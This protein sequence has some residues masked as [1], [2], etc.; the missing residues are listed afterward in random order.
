MALLCD[1]CVRPDLN[2]LLVRQ[3]RS[4]AAS[5]QRVAY[6][7]CH[8]L[9]HQWFVLLAVCFIACL[10]CTGLCCVQVRKLGDDAYVS[11]AVVTLNVVALRLSQHDLIFCCSTA[12]VSRRDRWFVRV[13]VCMRAHTALHFGN[14]EWWSEVRSL[15]V[16]QSVACCSRC[17]HLLWF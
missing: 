8:E 11:H 12:F 17:M 3:A 15:P 4:S 9:A 10:S 14:T 16:S 2:G 1:C 7:V 13:S 6:V 5:R